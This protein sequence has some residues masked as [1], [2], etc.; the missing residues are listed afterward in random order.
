[1]PI[2]EG[3]KRIDITFDNSADTGFFYHLPNK[4]YLPCQFIFIECKNYTGEIA[5]PELDQ[6]MGRFSNRR[7]RFGIIVCRYLDDNDLF[8][9]RCAD[10]Y[11][12]DNGLI[13]PIV[14]EDIITALSEFPQYGVNA[15]EKI[16][17]AKYRKITFSK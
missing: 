16:L 11:H 8:I 13:I 2:H 1:M 14:D 10:T 4:S 9:K 12:D 5:N 6:M 7:G 15:I 17:E 3:R